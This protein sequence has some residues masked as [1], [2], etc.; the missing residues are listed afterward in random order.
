VKITKR[1]L[2]RIIREEKQ[3]LLKE[4]S[5][6]TMG[7]AEEKLATAV[8]MFLGAIADNEGMAAANDHDY[9]LQQITG[10]VEEHLENAAY[11]AEHAEREE[12]GGPAPWGGQD[13]RHVDKDETWRG[14]K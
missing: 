2:R 12:E 7:E 3:R 8:N 14:K 5:G 1:Q 11:A 13:L 6:P 9:V 10:F 4:M